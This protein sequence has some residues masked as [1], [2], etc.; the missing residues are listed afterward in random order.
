MQ[1]PR[2]GGYSLHGAKSTWLEIKALK[3]YLCARIHTLKSLTEPLVLPKSNC[4]LFSLIGFWLL[5][6]QRSGLRGAV[7]DPRLT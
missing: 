2:Q 1:S 6:L 3:L 7:S 5:R 4:P